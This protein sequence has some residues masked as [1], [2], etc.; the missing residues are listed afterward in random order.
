[1]NY[2]LYMIYDVYSLK[3]LIGYLPVEGKANNGNPMESCLL[4]L[5]TANTNYTLVE[6]NYFDYLLF[7]S[8][9]GMRMKLIYYVVKTLV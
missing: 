8:L 2:M 6:L 4:E 7:Q 5:Q 9:S 1:M 3:V